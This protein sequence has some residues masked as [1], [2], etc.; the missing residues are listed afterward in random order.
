[1]TNAKLKNI[2]AEAVSLDRQMQEIE[3]RLGLIKD[4]LVAEAESRTEE[5]T[6]TDGGGWSWVAEGADG[7]IARITQQ[8]AKLKASISSDK[9]VEKAKTLSNN[10]GIF[11]QLFEA[12][13]T[14]K[15]AEDFRRRAESLLGKAGEK[16]VKAFSGKGSV[17]ISY[18][19]KQ[20]E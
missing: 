10:S 8:G 19:T 11:A 1:M 9:D 6:P 3:S 5:H 20:S 14:Y 16:L 12:H 2:V 7:C 17:S 4:Q 13:V 15:L 18:E